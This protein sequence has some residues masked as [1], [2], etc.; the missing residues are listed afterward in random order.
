[1]SG[2]IPIY[3]GQYG[4]AYSIGYNPEFGTTVGSIAA[5]NVDVI[6]TGPEVLTAGSTMVGIVG[7]T[8]QSLDYEGTA[9]IG[10]KYVGF[11]VYDASDGQ[12]YLITSKSDSFASSPLTID[13]AAN[14]V[15][16]SK[17]NYNVE[18][19]TATASCFLAGTAVTTPAGE[20]AVE[21]LRPGDLVVVTDGRAV[22]VTWV[23]RQ[24]V[25]TRFADP[26]RALPVRIR[27]EALGPAQ[28]LRDLLLSPDHAVLVDDVLVQAGALVN[29]ISILRETNMPPRFTYYHVE[30]ADHAL[31]L[32]EGVPAETFIDNVDRMAFDNWAEHEALNGVG[33]A[34]TEMDRPRAKAARQVPPGLRVRLA[35]RAAE[36]FGTPVASA[37]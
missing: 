9:I 7:K 14:P 29:G 4:Y 2:T 32:A 17:P 11:V 22:P 33:V 20:V 23:G 31:L 3:G 10:G 37:A 34:I 21:T 8:I 19:G 25:A 12:S 36:L 26:L 18:T 30:V 35:A 13:Y 6:T 24:T 28:P 16:G 5:T 27:A 15:P 1:M